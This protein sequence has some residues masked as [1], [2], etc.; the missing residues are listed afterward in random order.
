MAK[1]R[2]IGRPQVPRLQLERR[3]HAR[4]MRGAALQRLQGG[5]AKNWFEPSDQGLATDS[6]RKLFVHASAAGPVVGWKPE[7]HSC[8]IGLTV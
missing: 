6:W 2:R 5:I 3:A 8:A 7:I 1:E 4:A